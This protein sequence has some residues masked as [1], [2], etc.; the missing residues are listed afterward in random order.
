M[1]FSLPLFSYNCT[2]FKYLSIADTVR[3]GVVKVVG[4]CITYTNGIEGIPPPHWQPKD[5]EG[6]LHQKP[7]ASQLAQ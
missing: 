5:K 1:D 6:L 7:H 4:I 3:M 2:S